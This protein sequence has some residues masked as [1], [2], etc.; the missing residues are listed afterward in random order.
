MHFRIIFLARTSQELT[1][2]AQRGGV[3]GCFIVLY[4]IHCFIVFFSFSSRSSSSQ[5]PVIVHF[6]RVSQVS[7]ESRNEFWP[8]KVVRSITSW[9]LKTSN[10][11]TCEA[12]RSKEV[13]Q[14]NL[15]TLFFCW[16]LIGSPAVI[17]RKTTQIIAMN[18]FFFFSLE[19]YN[20]NPHIHINHFL[21]HQTAVS[22]S[23]YDRTDTLCS[24]SV[25][26]NSFHKLSVTSRLCRRLQHVARK[27]FWTRRIFQ[28]YMV[29]IGSILPK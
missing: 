3:S 25:S 13:T 26:P 20:C 28:Q 7:S 19:F 24:T 6:H 1:A 9:S 18:L 22:P 5:Q 14:K 27:L 21:F 11:W 15:F 12:T 16:M 17:S 29:L 23:K 2:R 8:L 10:K 4:C